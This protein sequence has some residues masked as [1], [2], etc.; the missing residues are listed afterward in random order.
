MLDDW[1]LKACLH[2][3]YNDNWG[4]SRSRWKIE[5][6]PRRPFVPIE[7]IGI[8]TT[9]CPDALRALCYGW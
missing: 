4:P 3:N 9:V 6:W 5:T 1:F 7:K 2:W 8:T